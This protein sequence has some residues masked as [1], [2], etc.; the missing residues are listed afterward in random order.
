MKN[1]QPLYKI[2]TCVFISQI[3]SVS[4]SAEQTKHINAE[5]IKFQ[6]A[7]VTKNK[8]SQSTQIEPITED[9]ILISGDQIKF[10]IVNNSSLHRATRC[11]H[12]ALN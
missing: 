4:L 9:T 5:N 3:I 10:F 1:F 12:I 7:F 2:F 11:F 8:A 6:W